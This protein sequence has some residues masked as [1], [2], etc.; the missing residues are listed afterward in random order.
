VDAPLE[1]TVTSAVPDFVADTTL[2]VTQALRNLSA[3]RALDLQDAQAR[4]TLSEARFNGGPGATVNATYGYNATGTAMNEV[5]RDL[6]QAQQFSL[7]VQVPVITWGARGADVQAAR[8][9]L[10]RVQSTS[11]VAREQARQDAHFA[12][13]QVSLA[14]RQLAIAA[15]ADTVAQKRF[16]V[17]YNRYVIGRIDVDQLYLA[18]NAKDQALLSYVQSLRGYWQAHYRLRRVTLYDFERGEGIR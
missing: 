6:Q 8:S 13:L 10:F 4:R 12:V 14:R 18:Q 16:E 7:S 15:K 2:A 17:S 3:V 5:Y 11:R 9:E 1:I